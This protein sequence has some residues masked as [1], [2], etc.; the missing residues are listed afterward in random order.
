MAGVEC[1]RGLNTMDAMVAIHTLGF[2]ASTYTQQEVGFALGRG[3][4][5]ISLEMGEQPTGFIS[6]R[7]SLPGRS[8]A[9]EE[10]AK[11]INRLLLADGRTIEKLR[12]VQAPSRQ[13]DDDI[14]F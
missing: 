9:A 5:V 1:C 10:I 4:K 11:E 12:A 14:P 3:V 7:Q 6:R 13:D 2:S 8:R